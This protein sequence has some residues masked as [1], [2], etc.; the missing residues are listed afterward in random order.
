MVKVTYNAPEGDEKVVTTR[1]HTFFDGHPLD[2]DEVEHGEL[3]AKARCNPHFSV[4]GEDA[5][6]EP[7]RRRGRPPKVAVDGEDAG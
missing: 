1:G 5:G 2:V 4:D 3:I 7:A 6:D